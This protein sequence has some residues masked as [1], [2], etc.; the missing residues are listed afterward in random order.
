MANNNS[1]SIEKRRA[2]SQNSRPYFFMLQQIWRSGYKMG[3]E[4][5]INT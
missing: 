3:I 4:E 5:L 1:F 2:V